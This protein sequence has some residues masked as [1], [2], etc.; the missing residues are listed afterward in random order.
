M[1]APVQS[2]FA[3]L[4]AGRIEGPVDVAHE[5]L[6]AL[7][8]FGQTPPGPRHVGQPRTVTGGGSFLRHLHAGLGEQPELLGGSTCLCTN[9][10]LAQRPM[11]Q[12]V[13]RG[14]TAAG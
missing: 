3:V 5:P 14:T 11:G 12:L 7:G 9:F 13:A 6:E 2:K 4:R 1:R 8:R 10:D